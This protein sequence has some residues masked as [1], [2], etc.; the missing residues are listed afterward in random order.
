MVLAL[1]LYLLLFFCF[2]F[3]CFYLSLARFPFLQKVIPFSFRFFRG[4]IFDF[5]SRSRVERACVAVQLRTRL[6]LEFMFLFYRKDLFLN[7]RVARTIENL[8]LPPV[9]QA[10]RFSRGF[11]LLLVC[12]A[13]IPRFWLQKRD[14]KP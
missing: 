8:N 3:P 2:F 6:M 4:I 12:P 1:L 13:R 11:L 9:N 14:K 5:A 10:A 7:R